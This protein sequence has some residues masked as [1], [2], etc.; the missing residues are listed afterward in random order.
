LAD[1]VQQPRVLH[2]DH[3]LRGEVL[4]KR[5][6]IIREWPDLRAVRGDKAEQSTVLAQRHKQNGSHICLRNQCTRDRALG[7]DL[8]RFDVLDLME[9]RAVY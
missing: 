5:N 1:F 8:D 9:A 7:A 2:R 3:C 4:E 6:L